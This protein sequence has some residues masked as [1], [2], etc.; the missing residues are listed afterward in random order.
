MTSAEEIARSLGRHSA[1]Q[2]LMGLAA[3]SVLGGLGNGLR[4]NVFTQLG[5]LGLKGISGCRPLEP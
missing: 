4:L 1:G 2:R 5:K 3:F